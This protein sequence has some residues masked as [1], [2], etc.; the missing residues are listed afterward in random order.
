M[1]DSS[2][3]DDFDGD[4]PPGPDQAVPATAVID[5]QGI[6]TGWSSE[7]ERLL[8]YGHDE[9]VGQPA[10][11]LLGADT[12]QA[13]EWFLAMPFGWGGRSVLRRRDGRHL[14][15]SVRIYPS[16]DGHGRPQRL[17]VVSPVDRRHWG[18]VDSVVEEAFDQSVLPMAIFDNELRALRTSKG[19]EREAGL[20][21]EQMRGRR[22]SEILPGDAGRAV[23]HG[24]RRVLETGE[25]QD[26]HLRIRSPATS[27]HRSWTIMLSPLAD[28]L[29]RTPRV[30]LTAVDTT[31]QYLA[32][33]R[34]ALL[35]ELST[36]IGSTLDVSRT[37]QEMADVVVGTL[38]DFVTVDLLDPLFRGVEPKA[39]DPGVALRR[40]AQQSVLPGLPE[41]VTPTGELDH[42]P[43]DSPP[44]FSLVTG[45]PSLHGT[46]DRAIDVWAA[47]DPGRA[48]MLR[49]HGIHS[50]MIIP[51]QARGI[52]LG[53]A[54]LAR[55]RRPEPFD[56]DDLQVAGEIGAR[57]AVAVDNARRYTRERATAL[58]LQRSL[59]PQ[60]IGPQEAVE[61]AS[62]YLPAGS[63][64]GVG[65]DWFDV[66]PLSGARVALVVGDVVG[67]GLRASAT[68]G[69]LRTAVRTLADVDLPPDEL[70]VHLDDLVAHLAA[71]EVTEPDGENLV[72]DLVATCLYLVYD[73]VSRRCTAASAGHPAPV[74]TTPDG[75][76]E[77]LDVPPG[78][79]LGLGGLPFETAERELDPGSLLL[80]YTNGLIATAD[81][82]VDTGTE[83]LRHT[84]TRPARPL[85]A[86]CDTLV[87]LV[88]DP[89][90]DDVAL[91]LARTKVLDAS[92]VVGWDVP[93][94]PAAVARIRAEVSRR[95][96]AWG[97]RD[98][99]YTVEL[100]VSELVTNAIRYGTP[101]IGLRV[102]HN[103]TLIVEVSD[104]SG[105]A[106]H[107]R[108][109]RVFDEGG[110]GLLLV[111]QVTER[112]GTRHTQEGKTIWAEVALAEARGGGLRTGA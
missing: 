82:D 89:P 41:S 77:L 30:Q 9:V 67:H 55:H 100:V 72:T 54:V 70:L 64:A 2:L 62:R 71:E 56:E 50:V 75:D 26:L 68:M 85:E 78:P 53:V 83:R 39:A 106:P 109:A 18:A 81:R 3:D 49:R 102:I 61:V 44:T 29:R 66:I 73:P 11:Q 4:R 20:S 40:A 110:R 8:G 105:T 96:A 48:E 86:V 59:L 5:A 15:V 92:Q 34:L 7:A 17:I 65:G 108:R 13:T 107:L 25:S 94:E 91:V 42:Y 46:V 60:R 98:I 37:A 84:L 23:E 24:V 90:D 36:R 47:G 27:A 31:E 74:L 32:R 80:L 28:P 79:P 22:P 88:P 10:G 16:L 12:A 35:N 14:D 111:A 19:M 51:L 57:A 52:T 87:G 103:S 99:T 1:R 104:G 6:V 33:E 43:Q 69:R 45:R 38:A 63:G 76:A 101:P 21:E 112:W 97:M 95:L 58:A 93:A